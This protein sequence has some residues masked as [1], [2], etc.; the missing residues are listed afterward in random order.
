MKK[1]FLVLLV[2]FFCFVWY[3]SL[4]QPSLDRDWADD[5]K[6]LAEITFSWASVEI[7]NVRDFIYQ[8]VNEYTENYYDKT[9]RF[10]DLV[11]LDYIIEPF[12]KYDGPAHTMLSFGFSDGDYLVISAEIRKEKGE[13]FSP[14]KWILNNYEIVY[15]IGSERDLVKLRANHRKDDVYVYPIKAETED[16]KALFVSMLERAESLSKN[17]EFYN[18]IFNNCTTS[19]KNHVNDFA[20]NKIPKTI[21]TFLPSKSDAIIYDMGLIDTDL[22]LEKAQE[23]FKINIRSEKYAESEN[24]SKEIRRNDK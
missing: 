24:Y 20:E 12:G 8:S 23:L 21:A 6:I 9:Y 4:K 5:Q 18:T 19:I 10:D 13:S 7:K 11:S 2:A 17:A 3:I 22:S 15:V 16:I 14:L 1:I